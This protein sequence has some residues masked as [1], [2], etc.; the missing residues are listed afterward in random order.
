MNK[1][2]GSKI[3][4]SLV[5]LEEV[6]VAGDGTRWGRCLHLRVNIDLHKPLERGNALNLGRKTYWVMFKYEK[7]PLFCFNC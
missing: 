3:E 2:V 7:L 4:E 1:G 5:N 6:D